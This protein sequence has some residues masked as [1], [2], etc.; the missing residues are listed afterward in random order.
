MNTA[1]I[2]HYDQLI[3]MNN[4]PVHDPAPLR[5][6][7]NKWDGQG[8]IDRML[9]DSSQSV[10]EIGVGTGRLALRVAPLCSNFHGID[11]SPKTIQRAAENLV[12]IDN[13]TLHC[14]DFLN[15]ELTQQYDVI[16]SSLTFMHICQKQRAMDQVSALLKPHG[17]FLLSI[18]KNQANLI[19]TGISRITVCPDQPDVTARLIR[20]S[21]LTLLEQYET[22]F[23]HIFVAEKP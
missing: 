2:L 1:V 20:S 5:E 19:D 16:Y 12:G 4:D 9:L 10:L 8:F 11:L 21:G 18:D 13:I 6:Y 22:E 15:F 17:R 23:A 7:M 14:G 3:E